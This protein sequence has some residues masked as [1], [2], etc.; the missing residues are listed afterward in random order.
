MNRNLCFVI[1]LVIMLSPMLVCTALAFMD[2]HFI[3]V[4]KHFQTYHE[5]MAYGIFGSFLTLIFSFLVFGDAWFPSETKK[6]E[7]NKQE[8]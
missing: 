3:Y 7:K 2:G 4:F 1:S 5:Y 8:F 6:T